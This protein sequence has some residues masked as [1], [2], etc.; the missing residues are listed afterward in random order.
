[1]SFI[2]VIFRAGR[3]ATAAA[4]LHDRDMAITALAFEEIPARRR[5]AGDGRLF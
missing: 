3:P 5:A 4:R 1:M 2:R